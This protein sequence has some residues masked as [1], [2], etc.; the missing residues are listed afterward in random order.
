MANWARNISKYAEVVKDVIP[1]E[2]AYKKASTE[3][4]VVQAELQVQLDALAK[5]KAE[6]AELEANCQ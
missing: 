6:V 5:V 2:E 3:L 4:A 1:K